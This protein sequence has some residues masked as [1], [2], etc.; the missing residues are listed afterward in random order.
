MVMFCYVFFFFGYGPVQLTTSGNVTSSAEVLQ[1]RVRTHLWSSKGGE[2]L[3]AAGV[4][5]GSSS[6]RLL[7][8]CEEMQNKALISGKM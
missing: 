1:E 6:F 5:G 8:N 4:S 3:K 7:S 2:G